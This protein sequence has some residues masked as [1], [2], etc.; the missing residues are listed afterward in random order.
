MIGDIKLFPADFAPQGWAVCDGAILS[1]AEN[2][3]LFSVI[4]TK[5]GGNGVTDFAIPNL[6][7]LASVDQGGATTNYLICLQG[8]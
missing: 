4:G 7:P 8:S 6:A 2:V 3:A 1:I 5:Y